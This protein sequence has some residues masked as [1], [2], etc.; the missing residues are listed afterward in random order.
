[1]TNEAAFMRHRDGYARYSNPSTG[2]QMSLIE[3]ERDR[4]QKPKDHFALCP[5]D[6]DMHERL[7]AIANN[8]CNDAYQLRLDL[9]FAPQIDQPPDEC[10]FK[11]DIPVV[12]C[13]YK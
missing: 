9:A 6:A 1:M 7:F 4:L 10:K 12:F 5:H 2:G 13:I 8:A 11:N 3:R